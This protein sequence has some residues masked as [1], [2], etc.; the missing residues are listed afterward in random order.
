MN[1]NQPQIMSPLSNESLFVLGDTEPYTNYNSDN[2]EEYYDIYDRIFMED[3][4]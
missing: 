2:D 1:Q 4:E 3:Q